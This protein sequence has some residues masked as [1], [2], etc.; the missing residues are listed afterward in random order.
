MDSIPEMVNSHGPEIVFF[1]VVVAEKGFFFKLFKP[2]DIPIGVNKNHSP[3]EMKGYKNIF[4][5]PD[6]QNYHKK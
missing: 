2:P 4:Y 6:W 3:V 5:L 1:L